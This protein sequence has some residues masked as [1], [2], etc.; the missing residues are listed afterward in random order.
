MKMAKSLYTID[1]YA[2][3]IR[4]T[5]TIWIVFNTF[6]NDV[7]GFK[8][9]IDQDEMNEKYLE[10]QFTDY[11][12]REDFLSFMAENFPDVELIEVFDLV[13]S[14]HV[15]WPYLGSLAINTDIG[16]DCYKALSEKYG[17]PY[18]DPV[19]NKALLWV[20]DFDD[21]KSFWDDKLGMI[22]DL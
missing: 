1:Q 20:I 18:E 3:T 5:T 2:A 10:K 8:H 21:A 12:E 17:D 13:T 22:E 11:Q 6:Y 14:S 15:I 4:K 7:H 16:S 19:S 9:K